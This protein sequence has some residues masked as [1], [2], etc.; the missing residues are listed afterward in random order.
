MPFARKWSGATPEAVGHECTLIAAF[1]AVVTQDR[2]GGQVFATGSPTG[3]ERTPIAAGQ[4][5]S[6]RRCRVNTAPVIGGDVTQFRA[7]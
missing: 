3:Q 7:S 4:G 5:V 6:L 2:A 1:R